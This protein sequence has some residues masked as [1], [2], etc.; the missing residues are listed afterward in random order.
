MTQ[1]NNDVSSSEKELYPFFKKFFE[2]RRFHVSTNSSHLGDVL[3]YH[4]RKEILASVEV[5]LDDA[6][7]AIGQA[8]MYSEYS[9]LVY[10]GVPHTA[11]LRTEHLSKLGIGLLLYDPSQHQVSQCLPAK[12]NR[13]EELLTRERVI[14][15]ILEQSG[16]L[17]DLSTDP[18]YVAK[19][20]LNRWNG[21]GSLL[22]GVYKRPQIDTIDFAT[23]FLEAL[24]QKQQLPT[25]EAQ[26]IA[27]QY[28]LTPSRCSYAVCRLTSLEMVRRKKGRFELSDN[29]AKYVQAAAEIWHEWRAS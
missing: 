2:E 17:S 1:P 15:E 24:K 14:R 4:P 11:R 22:Y 6:R 29:F 19:L 28:G 8:L 13:P 10:I 21:L 7:D 27:A 3:A 20:H 25:S 26:K 23:A 18:F 12:R 5:K 16:E 9:D